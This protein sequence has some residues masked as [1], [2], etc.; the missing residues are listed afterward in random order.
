MLGKFQ[1][2]CL[3]IWIIVGQVPTVLCGWGCFDMI[4]VIYHFSSLSPSLWE[5]VRCRLNL[6]LKE[7][8][9][10][11]K[12]TNRRL[13]YKIPKLKEASVTDTCRFQSYKC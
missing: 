7:P 1:C 2:R 9:N 13:S 10:P 6:C 11:N 4:S 8:L 5:T 3:T 12:S